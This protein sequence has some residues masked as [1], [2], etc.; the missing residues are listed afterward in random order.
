MMFVRLQ[1]TTVWKSLCREAEI[2]VMQQTPRLS[3]LRGL[4]LRKGNTGSLDE[5]SRMD[6]QNAVDDGISRKMRED[7]EGPVFAEA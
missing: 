5:R 6:G 2:Q 3:K 1:R 7:R 4:C